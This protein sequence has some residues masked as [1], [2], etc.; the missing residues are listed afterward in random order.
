MDN[1][2]KWD[3]ERIDAIYD[4]IDE[5][6]N[7]LHL[8][9]ITDNK[10]IKS[11]L[12]DTNI[13]CYDVVLLAVRDN[14]QINLNKMLVEKGLAATDPESEGQL[15]K[16]PCIN[17]VDD[18]DEDWDNECYER[19]EQPK[20]STPNQSICPKESGSEIEFMDNLN[21][22]NFEQEQL[23]A[24]M[25]GLL[26]QQNPNPL[27]TLNGKD[28]NQLA[29][30]EENDVDSRINTDI[31][32]GHNNDAIDTLT[33]DYMMR[34]T[35]GHKIEYRFN[36]PKIHWQQN[37]ELIVLKINAQD[38]VKYGLEVTDDYLIYR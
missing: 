26:D 18:E 20:Y 36:H 31:S 7:E 3:E 5:Y 29:T 1:A 28:A 19:L 21:F 33:D 17:E 32:N 38:D 9:T 22:N 16:V 25:R 8:H 12:V 30:I 23:E 37:E 11:T 35:D 6:G 2:T 4:A 27:K 14:E 15:N 10:A 13:M 24:F 34:K